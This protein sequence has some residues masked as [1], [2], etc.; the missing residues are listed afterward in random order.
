MNLLGVPYDIVP[1]NLLKNEQSS[2]AYKAINPLGTVPAIQTCE[3]GEIIWQSLAIIDY[4]DTTQKLLPVNRS[5]RA[6]CWQITNTICSEI[7]P[8]QNLSV[9][10]QIEAIGGKEARAEWAVHHNKS[11]LKTIETNLIAEGSKYAVSDKITLAD[12]CMVPQLYS[13]R[14]FGIDIEKEFPKMYSI[15]KRLETLEAFERAHPHS[16]PDCPPDIA[17]LGTKF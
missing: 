13:A 5:D 16:Q 9:L 1:I 14:R 17:S 15:A 11:K 2:G 8:L 3:S 6:R 4:F 12:I 10:G 7:Q